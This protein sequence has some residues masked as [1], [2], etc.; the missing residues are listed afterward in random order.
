MLLLFPAALVSSW[1]T[2]SSPAPGFESARPCSR[3]DSRFLWVLAM[4]LPAFVLMMIQATT[5]HDPKN[6]MVDAER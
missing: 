1:A 6:V 5:N 2:T 3:D 4:K